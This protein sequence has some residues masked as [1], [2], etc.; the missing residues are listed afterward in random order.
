MLQPCQRQFHASSVLSSTLVLSTLVLILSSFTLSPVHGMIDRDVHVHVSKTDGLFIAWSFEFASNGSLNLDV[1][2]QPS[3]ATSVRN[4]TLQFMLMTD[5]QVDP[6]RSSSMEEICQHVPFNF[7]ETTWQ[8]QLGMGTESHDPPPPS[9]SAHF[10]DHASVHL[11]TNRTEWLHLLVLNCDED[12]F[13]FTYSAIA[14]NPG[15]D[16]LSVS[17]Q[18]YKKLYMAFMIIWASAAGLWLLHIFLYRAWNVALQLLMTFLPLTKLALCIL[19]RR[20]YLHAS[21]AGYWLQ[22]IRTT[23]LFLTAGDHLIWFCVLYLMACGWRIVKHRL[24]VSE[25]KVMAIL[26]ACLVSAYAIYL[27]LGGFFIFLLMI[28]FILALRVVVNDLAINANLLLRQL[29]VVLMYDIDWER[30]PIKQKLNIFKNLQVSIVTYIAIAV[31]LSLWS[32]I[33][34]R[35][36]PWISDAMQNILSVLF[37]LS[38]A[39]AFGLRPFNPYYLHII[40]SL[41]HHPSHESADSDYGGVHV[42]VS[43]HA[44]SVSSPSSGLRSASGSG[45]RADTD[46]RR[47]SRLDRNNTAADYQQLRDQDEE[48]GG[49][50][51]R[52]HPS[53]TSSCSSS[54][55]SMSRAPTDGLWHPGCPIPPLP[56]LNSPSSP[57]PRNNHPITPEPVLLLDNPLDPEHSMLIGQA[58]RPMPALA[59]DY[60]LP[61]QAIPYLPAN[62]R[63]RVQQARM[64]EERETLDHA[65]HRSAHSRPYAPQHP[66]RSPQPWL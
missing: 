21:A 53:A 62:I 24:D 8:A 47:R 55:S 59:D 20:Y 18:P 63:R 64:E 3:D 66:A 26:L 35:N 33:F 16:Y 58:V 27:V 32:D 37:C 41:I 25:M 49:A 61:P 60:S 5:G 65:H 30:T 19:Y 52:M 57:L 1:Q 2:L 44:A 40:W 56:A 39:Y 22:D 38:L 51:V 15:G 29:H 31:I 10:P 9:I 4:H 36:D 23:L 13:D 11:N 12:S 46:T 14:I 45:S 50:E 43:S 54:C 34:L 28:A 42:H 7:V 48:Q 6:V 17:D